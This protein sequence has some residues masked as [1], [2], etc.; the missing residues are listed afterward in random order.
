M[1][2]IAAYPTQTVGGGPLIN[3]LVRHPVEYPITR[4][5]YEDGGVD[6]NVSPC[7]LLRWELFYEGLTSAELQ[8]LVDHFNLAKG[9]VNDF[10]FYDHH[11]A[12]TYSGVAYG[13]F[14]INDHRH[15]ATLFANVVLLK[16]L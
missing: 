7:G 8:T 3:T 5:E 11:E 15:K 10:N 16:F 14:E 4:Y 13:S 12:S 9:R 6:V 1:A 2:T